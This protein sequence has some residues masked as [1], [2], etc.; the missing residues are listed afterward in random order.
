MQLIQI[1][2][3]N[4]D[5]LLSHLDFPEDIVDDFKDSLYEAEPLPDDL[6]QTF[7]SRAQFIEKVL[8]F[9]DCGGETVSGWREK[10]E[11]SMSAD[12]HVLLTDY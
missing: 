11:E 10:L 1:K 6:G 9:E 7:M 8:D 3:V 5:A 12:V 2:A 4:L